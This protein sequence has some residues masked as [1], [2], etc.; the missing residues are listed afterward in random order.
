MQALRRLA[1]PPLLWALAGLCG[2]QASS[3]ANAQSGAEA[4]PRIWRVCVGDQPILPYITNDP[5]HP[6]RAE[7]LLVAAG[8]L[9]DLSVQL[10]RYPFR[11][12]RIMMANGDTD[13]LLAGPTPENLE[14][15]RFPLKSGALDAERRIARLNLVWVRRADSRFDWDGKRITGMPDERTPK[16]GLRAGQR[17]SLNAVRQMPVLVDETALTATLQLRMLAAKR[18]DLAL[19]LQD[20]FEIALADPE[21]KPLVVLPR[22]LLRED[23]FA[24]IS[25]K[26]AAAQL[27]M[28]ERLW[29]AMGKLRDQP[30]F[31]RD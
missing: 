29:N 22:A 27:P 13:M 15:F 2:A 18:F 10:Q 6:G 20:E 12:C 17:V 23:F 25:Q 11:R 26:H 7:R 21:L 4:P 31:Q 3:Q 28:A 8:K 30:E 16:V 9:A 1:L 19:G 14:E 24:V 5:R